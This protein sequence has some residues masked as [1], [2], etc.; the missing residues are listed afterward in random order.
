M[1]LGQSGNLINHCPSNFIIHRNAKLHMISM[2]F[3][4]KPMLVWKMMKSM[5]SMVSAVRAEQYQ[6]ELCQ[7][8]A[9]DGESI[10]DVDV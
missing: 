8:T 10:A 7:L 4:G 2:E 3:Q 9:H 5:Y 1:M 6:E